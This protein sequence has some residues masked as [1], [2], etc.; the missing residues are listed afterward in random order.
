MSKKITF[1]SNEEKAEAIALE[2][3]N[4]PEPTAYQA[5]HLQALKEA[6]VEE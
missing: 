6:E 2:V 1:G 4:H 3:K 5:E